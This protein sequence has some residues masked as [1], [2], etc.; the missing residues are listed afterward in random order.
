[1]NDDGYYNVTAPITPNTAPIIVNS[2][3]FID[4]RISSLPPI[5]PS[6]RSMIPQAPT[7]E[8]LRFDFKSRSRKRRTLYSMV[9]SSGIFILAGYLL[10]FSSETDVRLVAVSL[11]SSVSSA[12][13]TNIKSSSK[14]NDADSQ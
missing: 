8:K 11:L 10:A 12:W 6:P 2:V 1:M 7:L 9:I 13:L 5:T 14:N 3:G 4:D